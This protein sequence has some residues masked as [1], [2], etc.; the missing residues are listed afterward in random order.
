MDLNLQNIKWQEFV[1]DE[2]FKISAT[3]SGIDRNKLINRH[4]DTPYITRSERD[5]GYDS[6]VCPQSEKYQRNDGNVIS[7][8]LDTQTVFFQP[9]KFYTG[10]N[11]Q[12][13]RSAQLN[14]NVAMF[15]VPLL[16]TQMRK[17]SWG[18]NG[19]T[20]TRLKRS[21]ILL[22]VTLQDEPDYTFME[23]YMRQK[24][25]EKFKVYKDYIS[26]RLEELKDVK[27]VEALEEKAWG[28]FF[29]H[30]IFTEIQR[31]KRL[32]KADHKK[33]KMPYISSTALNNGVDGY[34]GNKEKVRIFENCLTLANS[35]S[36]GACFYQPFELIAS[37]H[38]TKLQNEN[39]NKYTYQFI[40]SI[41][42][43]LSEK[44]S[45]N[46]EI[47]DNRI[48]KEKIMLPINKNQKPDYEYMENYMKRLEYG[49]LKDYLERKAI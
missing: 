22:P 2:I 18:G 43:R 31:G 3:L 20:L 4:G 6:F 28:E 10:Q 15:L 13:M 11:I 8:G 44:Y 34:V 25:Q 33:G 45:F 39:F 41:V 5:N 37:D 19:A 12:I 14:K 27:E 35:G 49:K 46:R 7:I 24:E 40:A 47:N 9:Y 38:V 16:K 30:E 48:K 23:A 17:F 32:K 1:L 26:K 42:S 21:K 29:L 36:V